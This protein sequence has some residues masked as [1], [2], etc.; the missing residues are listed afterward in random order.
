MAGFVLFEETL[1]WVCWAHKLFHPSTGIGFS[2]RFAHPAELGRA[3]CATICRSL[4]ILFSFAFRT[5]KIANF[6]NRHV[7]LICLTD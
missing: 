6:K 3:C 5:A 2:S 4:I 1:E 7:K